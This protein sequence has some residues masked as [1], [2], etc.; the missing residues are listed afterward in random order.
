MN[1]RDAY[2]LI[3]VDRVYACTARYRMRGNISAP[4]PSVVQQS[5]VAVSQTA[6]IVLSGNKTEGSGSRW[7]LT[8]CC[9]LGMRQQV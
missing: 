8:H 9:R 5:V 2:E 7:L 3:P 1:S 4:R 6:Y